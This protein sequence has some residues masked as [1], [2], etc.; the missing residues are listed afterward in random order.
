MQ[1]KWQRLRQL[2]AKDWEIVGQVLWLLPWVSFRIRRLGFKQ[3]KAQLTECV[4]C[5]DA[6]KLPPSEIAR[7]TNSMAHYLGANCLTRSLVLWRLLKC[8]SIES[9]LRFG[10]RKENQ[11]LFAHAWVELNG[12]VLNDRPDIDQIY[13]PITVFSDDGLVS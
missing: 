7:I 5:H 4:P 6:H 12:V 2:S 13:E 3:T 8:R 11:I 1:A 10:I 9:Q